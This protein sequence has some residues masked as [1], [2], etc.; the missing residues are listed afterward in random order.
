MPF[1]PAQEEMP[2]YGSV[3]DFTFQDESGKEIH[4]SDLNGR[5]WI[6]DFVFTR[7]QGQCPLMSSRMSQLQEP[8]RTSGVRLVSF[9][10]DPEHDTP[11]VLSAYAR[12]FKAEEGIWFFLTGDKQAMW[13]FIEAGFQLGVAEPTQKDLTSGAEA[14]MHSSRFVLVDQKGQIR[15]YYDTSESEKM[16]ALIGDASKLVSEKES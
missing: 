7:C 8:L 15:G 14:V 6:A 4:L 2:I 12:R 9:S 11:E 1:L 10:V 3:P 16:K 5:V 13:D